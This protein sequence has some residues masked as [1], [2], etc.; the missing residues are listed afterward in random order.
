VLIDNVNRPVPPNQ[1]LAPDVAQCEQIVMRGVITG[2][3]GS[4]LDI[5]GHEPF[6]KTGTTDGQGDAWF[7]GATPQLATAVWFG[8]RTTNALPAGF[9]GAKAGPIWRAFMTD[10]LEGQPNIPLPDRAANAVCNRPGKNINEDG[11]HGAPV[12]T[13]TPS[14]GAS[15]AAPAPT[16]TQPPR[17]VAPVTAP[18]APPGPTTPPA[19]SPGDG[20]GRKP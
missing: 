12:G 8:N 10:A 3:T 14:G 15:A 20:P 5:A 19:T 7:V 2:G 16:P 6:G 13:F 9:G 4:G 18:T 11:G 17:V 1:A